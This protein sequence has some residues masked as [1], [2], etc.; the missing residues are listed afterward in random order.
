[1]LMYSIPTLGGVHN[2][3][4][5]LLYITFPLICIILYSVK[6]VKQ[7]VI[8]KKLNIRNELVEKVNT[9]F[10]ENRKEF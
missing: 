9:G 4:I 6:E 3:C 5:I 10:D 1:M 2:H 7:L 8:V